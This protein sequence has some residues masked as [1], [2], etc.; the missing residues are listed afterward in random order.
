MAMEN[1]KDI[2]GYEGK[3][4]VSDLG[5]IKSLFRY[6][7][8][9]KQK[10]CKTGYLSV[11]LYLNKKPKWFLTHRLVAQNFILNPENKPEV[12]HKDGVKS[13]NVVYN[14]EWT[15]KSENGLH[16]VDIG[17][18]NIIGENN[19]TSKLTNEDVTKIKELKGIYSQRELARMFGVSKGAIYFIHHKINWKRHEENRT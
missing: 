17:L 13:N 10:I 4:Q 7:I 6:K 15:T 14:L 11:A 18:H 12:N 3:Y 19:N 16:A 1:W 2:K 8:T 5:N 9:L